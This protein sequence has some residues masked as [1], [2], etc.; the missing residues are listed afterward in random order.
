M[1]ENKIKFSNKELVVLGNVL[2]M[3][4]LDNEIHFRDLRNERELRKKIHDY[5]YVTCVKIEN[6]GTVNDPNKKAEE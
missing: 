2:D 1:A 4:I 6:F 5:L 3:Y